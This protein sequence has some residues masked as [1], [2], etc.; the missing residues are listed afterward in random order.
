MSVITQPGATQLTRMPRAPSS[1]ASDFVS[2]MIAP[3]VAA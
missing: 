2:A 1:E 3:F